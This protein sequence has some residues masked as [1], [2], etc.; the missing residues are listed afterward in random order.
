MRA[1]SDIDTAGRERPPQTMARGPHGPRNTGVVHARSR[2][3]DWARMPL[4]GT[5]RRPISTTSTRTTYCRSVSLAHYAGENSAHTGVANARGGSSAGGQ[6]RFR[7]WSPAWRDSHR[8]QGRRL[9]LLSPARDSID[10]R[11]CSRWPA[12]QRESAFRHRRHQ[13][14]ASSPRRPLR[15]G[16]SLTAASRAD[17]FP[18]TRTPIHEGNNILDG[19]T[20]YG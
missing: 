3:T 5:R 16:P 10:S 12:R 11:A 8:N 18:P 15:A 9:R 17:W 2:T 6:V 20:F 1:S 13:P 19:G 7:H 14:R 4:D